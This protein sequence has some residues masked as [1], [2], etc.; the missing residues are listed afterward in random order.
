[1]PNYNGARSGYAARVPHSDFTASGV[2]VLDLASVDSNLKGFRSGFA[3]STHAYYVP[4]YNG[5]A[6]SGYAARVSLSDFTASGVEILNLASINSNLK[7]FKG[8]FATSTHAYY[9]PYKN[10]G[11]FHGYT[12]RVSL[13]DFTTSGVEYLNLAGVNGNLKGFVGGFATS[14]HAYYAPYRN[15]AYNGYAP[16]VALSDFTASGVEILNLASTDGN[17]KGFD[18]GFATANHAYYVPTYNN[19]GGGVANHGYAPRVSLSI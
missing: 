15:S 1:M 8:G 17:L 12:A 10:E 9:V 7:G 13:S 6:Y 11:S 16:R 14:T 4:Y 3:T 19:V 18:G 5:G 2:E